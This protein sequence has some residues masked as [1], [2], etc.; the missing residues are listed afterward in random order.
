MVHD[1]PADTPHQDRRPHRAACPLDHVPARRGGC[2]PT[3][4][5]THPRRHPWPPAFGGTDMTKNLDRITHNKPSAAAP[6]GAAR[7]EHAEIDTCTA[8]TSASSG[9]DRLG[10]APSLR[11]DGSVRTGQGCSAPSEPVA[12]GEPRATWGMSACRSTLC[13]IGLQK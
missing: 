7:A 10:M 1:E 8:A 11:R 6:T 4:L 9:H 13:S 5:S 12:S 2:P 3:A